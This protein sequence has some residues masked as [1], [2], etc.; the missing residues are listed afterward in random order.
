M[1]LGLLV[2]AGGGSS[3]PGAFGADDQDGVRDYSDLPAL[4]ASAGVPV[5]VP[6]PQQGNTEQ[7]D[8]PGMAK[9]PDEL[10][11]GAT[12]DASL[13]SA[14]AD[15]YQFEGGDHIARVYPGVVNYQASAG[16]WMPIDPL[17][18]DVDGGWVNGANSINLRF[19]SRLSADSP[20]VFGLP[21]GSFSTWLDGGGAADGTLVDQRTVRYEGVLPG[22]DAAYDSLNSGVEERLVIAK[23]GTSVIV[24]RFSSKD[25][26]FELDKENVIHLLAGDQEVG[27][28]GPSVATDS[29]TPNEDGAEPLTSVP[30]Y[31][32]DDLGGGEYALSI[33]LDD[34]FLARATFPVTIDPARSAVTSV[35]T[36]DGWVDV[37]SPT[38]AH[39]GTSP[40]KVA[41]SAN[42]KFAFISFDVSGYVQADR[43][44][45]TAELDAYDDPPNSGTSGVR[46]VTAT[47]PASGTLNWNN[48]PNAAG[49]VTDSVSDSNGDGWFVWDV[50]SIYQGIID[51]T[52]TGHGL[53][54]ES[55]SAKLF[56]STESTLGGKP[57]LQLFYNDRPDPPTLSKPDAGNPALSTPSPALK[58][59]VPNDPN[60]DDVYIR[61]QLCLQPSSGAYDCGVRD[62]FDAHVV[63]GSEWLDQNDTWVV[64]AGILKDGGN[65][66][67]R[68]QSADGPEGGAG[69]WNP[70]S[71]ERFPTSVF[72]QFTVTLPH[73]G[74]N[75]NWGMWQ[76]QAGN[77]VDLEVNS[78]SGNLYAEV[79]LETLTSPVG[80]LEM[81][82]VYNSQDGKDFGMG[83]GWMPVI[84]SG[85]DPHEIPKELTVED[86]GE[87]VAIRL[88]DGQRL[89][90]AKKSGISS[91]GLFQG[92]G[93]GAGTVRQTDDSWT[94]HTVSGGQYVFSANGNL[95][96]ANPN[97]TSYGE[98]GLSYTFNGSGQLTRVTDPLDV[99]TTNER[100]VKL[101]YDTS[102]R[103]STISDWVPAG[104]PNNGPNVWT[105]N[106]TGTATLPTSITDPLG[107][108]IGLS[109]TSD[110][111]TNSVKLLS[112]VTDSGTTGAGHAWTVVYQAPT[113]SLSYAQV[114]S[115]T[116]PK[117]QS[118]SGNAT[119]F[120]YSSPWTGQ[121]ADHTVIADPRAAGAAQPADYQTRYD[122]NDQGLPIQLTLPEDSDNHVPVKTLLWDQ[123]GNLVC[124]REPAANQVSLGCDDPSDPYANDELSTTSQYQTKPPYGLLSSTQPSPV[125]GGSVSG[126]TATYQYDNDDT[127]VGLVQED[128]PN[129][130]FDGIP[131][132]KIIDDATPANID[133]GTG[134]PTFG[135]A[136]QPSNDFTVRWSGVVHVTGAPDG[137]WFRFR[138]GADDGSRLIVNG[139]V[140]GT[141]FSRGAH[142]FDWTCGNGEQ[143]IK[144]WNGD[145]DVLVEYHD[146][147]GNAQVDFE[148]DAGNPNGSMVN[149]PGSTT[150]PDLHLL[151]QKVETSDTHP[152]LTT[153]Y[154]YVSKVRGLVDATTET[155]ASDATHPRII[156]HPGGGADYDDYGRPLSEHT[157]DG[158]GHSYT[159]Q[160]T[161][162]AQKGCVS[163][164]T[165]R[166]GAV[167]NTTCD[168]RGNLTQSALIVP[169]PAGLDSNPTL[170][171]AQTRT[172]DTAYD[173]LG[174][175]TKISLPDDGINT[176][177]AKITSYYPN[178]L[179][180][181]TCLAPASDTDCNPASAT[182]RV[183]QYTYY[184]SGRVATM[185]APAV[186]PAG[187]TTTLVTTTYEYDKAGNVNKL[188]ESA[189][190]ETSRVTDTV[191]DGQGRPTS[192]TMP[193]ASN[194]AT[195]QYNDTGQG[196][197]LTGPVVT[198]TDT[199]GVATVSRVDPLDRPVSSKLGTL[200]AVT[201]DYG[202]QVSSGFLGSKTI[203]EWGIYTKTT[204]TAWGEAKRV[205]A[206]TGASGAAKDIVYT[207][208]AMGRATAVQDRNTNTTS[209]QYDGDGRLTQSSQTIGGSAKTWQYV[210][211]AAG[212]RVEVKD[213]D[214]RY[215]DFTYD[216]NG[217]PTASY[218]Y[219]SN[220]ANSYQGRVNRLDTTNT[221]DQ[222][223]N[224]SK[225]DDPLTGTL[226]F[227]YDHLGQLTRRQQTISGTP[228]GREDFTYDVWGHQTSAQTNNGSG[229]DELW[230]TYDAADRTDQVKRGATLGTATTETDYG[231]VATTGR[232]DTIT[233]LVGA[234]A[235]HYNTNGQLSQV[236]D[237]LTASGQTTYTYDY[238]ARTITRDDPASLRTIRSFDLAGR[239]S[240]QKVVKISAP[241]TTLVDFTYGYDD[242]SNVTSADQTVGGGNTGSGSWAYAYDEAG[243]LTSQNPPGASN[244]T[245][246][247]YDGAGNRTSATFNAGTAVT[248]TYDGA[249]RPIKQKQGAT[250]LQDYTY[251][252]AGELTQ[253]SINSGATVW[254]YTY[255][256]WGRQSQAKKT[257]GASVTNL[258]YTYDALGRTL[259]R[260]KTSAT[261]TNYTYQGLG[262]DLVKTAA[263]STI[264]YALLPSGPLAQKQG[265]TVRV[266]GRNLHGDV[267]YLANPTNQAI[268]D[269]LTYTAWGEKT[270]TGTD[271]AAEALTYQ[272][273]LT[274][275]DTGNVDMGTRL[276]DP[277]QGRF[278]TRD[279]LFGDPTNPQTL[280]PYIYGGDSPVIYTDP[281]GMSRTCVTTCTAKEQ[282]Q[283]VKQSAQTVSNT[284]A[285]QSS[286]NPQSSPIYFILQRQAAPPP[287]P[288]PAK[289][290]TPCHDRGCAFTNGHWDKIYSSSDTNFCAVP[291]VGF[292]DCVAGAIGAGG[293]GDYVDA[294]LYTVGAVTS[295]AGGG[296]A[297]SGARM[298]V[299]EAAPAVVRR[300]WRLG[301]PIDALTRAGNEPAW[302]TVR[303]RYW[304]NTAAAAMKNEYSTVN[305]VRMRRGVAPLDEKIGVSKELHHVVSR[306]E[307]G[308]NS[309]SNLAEVWPWEHAALD[310]FRYYGGPV[311]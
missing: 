84:G 204:Y 44:V 41:P 286:Y 253:T 59:T 86:G 14:N 56:Y 37:T 96:K 87:S 190:G 60:G 220:S 95:S 264:S 61:Y 34:Q 123:N 199:G 232:L 119:T 103:L 170:Q 130:T 200:P 21:E 186:D 164:V 290:A 68:A 106:Y 146:I 53:R 227:T 271:G 124:A 113:G 240:D 284:I 35:A 206:P 273:D 263:A 291:F 241:G 222:W 265:S 116:V 45:Y 258:D 18:H 16:K 19:P 174:R 180:K 65:F 254:D 196:A 202:E 225:T 293:K 267:A 280:N 187:A 6:D 184:D 238:V 198:A 58:A 306:A 296:T 85:V 57:Q 247:Q 140:M 143:K 82:L 181:W 221:Y 1:L 216:Q 24:E 51:G 126:S 149:V 26:R 212:E 250:V 175:V 139:D 25:F 151:T 176:R 210:Y 172:T 153:T 4:P 121:L 302:S 110:A 182:Q 249:N 311:P 155:D 169:T 223:G 270:T 148:W 47:W 12:R 239:P 300:G 168:T 269:T 173:A 308:S 46:E 43:D 189:P 276:Y 52:Q 115:V 11:R 111:T 112:G 15:V 178:G 142:A 29:S 209:Y 292:F 42:T 122:F 298:A 109:Y 163:Q 192:V 208:D 105:V 154:S 243:R 185:K 213:P 134:H 78:A 295:F 203:D 188:T 48:Q 260:A 2:V 55:A 99:T 285:A 50:K 102:N 120:S 39:E 77:G 9:S 235:Y 275:P 226:N 305:L 125:W 218:E 38:A 49:S 101:G 197:G 75:E 245:T 309:M 74:S 248:T 215:R 127:L 166:A 277:T 229:T 66:Y 31:K 131:D 282:K 71:G 195:S 194:A 141:C 22:V 33:S 81:S 167:T 17:L 64:P 32:L 177:M 289:A 299:E 156:D 278:T 266:I 283:A 274:D 94:W 160:T 10:P 70:I 67:W 54:L 304:K 228:S 150:Q 147:S 217:N 128:Y 20:F 259:S 231:Y 255:D 301:E 40:L 137:K 261:T 73:L 303:G 79:P 193:G 256:P 83:R 183:V 211:D 294:S 107:K 3:V 93:A 36:R 288:A 145:H 214:G 287:P 23:P 233:D 92:S 117:D 244:T 30:A 237:P 165:D 5:A 257:V 88:R 27:W 104:S 138:L 191:S 272:A 69:V 144:L 63:A 114:V 219:K 28:I 307:G 129:A 7:F 234:T 224:L 162:D 80:P 281:T 279:I 230:I 252:N 246:Y 97:T 205:T 132:Y 8:P 158:N 161:Y 310:P 76:T 171:P 108:V 13:S 91:V 268:T 152:T 133:W 135:G 236:D 72:R 179:V 207:Y 242:D 136:S 297:T 89:N 62:D 201:T 262:D 98:P 251:D 90:F 100:R 159:V 157:T 118:G